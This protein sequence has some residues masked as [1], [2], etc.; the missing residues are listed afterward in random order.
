MKMRFAR[1]IGI[2]SAMGLLVVGAASL[3]T[4]S[5]PGVAINWKSGKDFPSP[6][7]RFDG[8][9]VGSKVY[10]LGF[11]VDDVGTTDGSIWYY[12]LKARK[13]VDTKVDMKVPISNYSV[14]V[15]KDDTGTGLYTFGGRDANGAILDTVQVY[16]PA[17]GVVKILKSDKW[18]GKTPSDCVSLPG[19]GTTVV[20]NAAYVLG[21]MSFSTSIPACV[22]DQSREVWKFDPMAAAGNRWKKQPPLKVALGYISPAV[23]GNKIY[24]VG[25]DT[26]EAATLVAQPTVQS[27]KVGA[28]AWNDKDVADLPEACD[29]S[30]AFG[31]ASGPLDGTV[32]L[33]GCGQWPN[34]LADVLQY[35][36]S[37]NKWNNI[38][39]LLEARRNHA[40]VNI[41]TD[42]KPKLMVVGGY[43]SDASVILQTSE[44]G[45]TGALAGIVRHAQAHGAFAGKAAAF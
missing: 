9:K 5:Q 41:G 15:L 43:N 38:G 25:G 24:A 13:Y 39:S 26:N 37:T 29:E 14:A 23:I 44:I 18:P 19:T 31:F 35:K 21:G 2:A 22:D 32:T 17:S 40:G 3:A 4:A 12:D 11:R 45:T 1:G 42:A 36:V 8:A 10:F 30:Q 6:A 28:A 33:A 27:W 16:Y 34:A 7:T 20:G